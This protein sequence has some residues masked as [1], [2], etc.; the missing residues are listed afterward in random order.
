MTPRTRR[1]V[2]AVLYEAFGVAIVAPALSL[3][4]DRTAGSTLALSVLM[5]TVALIWSGV[6]NTLF[7][8]WEA[9]L[10]SAGRP[11]WMRI[12]H[13]VGFEGGLVLML[14]PIMARWLEISLIEALLA[15]LGILVFFFVYA[16]AFNWAFDRV[17]GL[18][19]SAMRAPDTPR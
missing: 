18:P 1:V 16:V 3:L 15:D 10:A 5:S 19:E 4:F 12:I 13:G 2:Q 6:F 8:R 17:F 14:V 7:E 9:G 11:F